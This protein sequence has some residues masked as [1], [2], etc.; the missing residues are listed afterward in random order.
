[1]P[2]A[3]PAEYAIRLGLWLAEREAYSEHPDTTTRVVV[4]AEDRC[5]SRYTIAETDVAAALARIAELETENGR[6]REG[7]RDLAG[8]PDGQEVISTD[9][10]RVSGDGSHV[11][12]GPAFVAVHEE[13][14]AD[15]IERLLDEKAAD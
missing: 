1:M 10:L 2:G 5:S 11:V 8:M 14:L 6:L 7:L 13:D 12:H 9:D 4:N 15:R 3:D